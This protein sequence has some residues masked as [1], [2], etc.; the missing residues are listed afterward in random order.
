M[1]ILIF[2]LL[3]FMI[4]PLKGSNQVLPE[5]VDIRIFSPEN[6]T[7]FSLTPSAG[8][9]HVFDHNNNFL[10][11]LKYHNTLVFEIAPE[12]INVLRNDSVIF[13]GESIKLQGVAFH[14]S[15]IIKPIEKNL[16][17]RGYDGNLSIYHAGN[18]FKLIN[19]TPLESYVA[20]TV[21]S[22]S[23]FNRHNVFYQVQAII[24]RTYALKNINRH[25]NEGHHLCDQ[26][27]CQAYYGKTFNRDIILAVEQT[28]GEVVTDS[29]SELLNTVYHA[30]CG[31]QT[32]N[33]EDLWIQALPYLRS[34][35]DTFCL[36]M[37]GARWETTIPVTQ[38]LAFLQRNHNLNL[39]PEKWE[40]IRNFQQSNRIHYL[41][42]NQNL[43]L[44]NIRHHFRLRSTFFS[45]TNNQD[46]LF[47]T[48]RGY[49]HGVGLC[50]E[51]AMQRARHGY[52]RD[53]ILQ[54][55]YKGALIKALESPVFFE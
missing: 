36:E 55:Y 7:S 1:R 20:G 34:D 41:D 21:Q 30:N 3:L 32:V 10:L 14:N 22:E 54:F 15:F 2:Y 46:T 50:Q 8:S 33:S 42:E 5:L 44:S 28:R 13:T 29:F 47:L 4:L 19:N 52:P 49:G 9:Y 16:K 11:E 26:V 39:T 18:Q 37:P 43:P 40:H 23:G 24:I 53:E 6:I 31:G 51:G 48:G 27:H 35:I 25:L 17:F 45:M 38:F 12:N